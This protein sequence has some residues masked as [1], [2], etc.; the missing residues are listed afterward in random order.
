M[1]VLQSLILK[2]STPIYH[3]I[4]NTIT[5]YFSIPGPSNSSTKLIQNHI[6]Q[7][8]AHPSILP[9]P[10]SNIHSSR[11]TQPLLPPS[12]STNS[13]PSHVSAVHSST[14]KSGQTTPTNISPSSL[15]PVPVSSLNA[16]SGSQQKTHVYSHRC[17]TY[18]YFLK[19]LF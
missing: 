11:H 1:Q 9:V 8:T 14:A 13:Q 4:L 18:K 17:V 5:C 2:N 3:F 7:S 16:S 19:L 15:L 10:Q 6:F 12:Q